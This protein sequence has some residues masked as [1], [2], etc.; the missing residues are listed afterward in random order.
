MASVPV[1]SLD[2]IS[3]LILYAINST[4]S[5]SLDD[6]HLQKIIFQ[7]LKLLK[8]NPEDFG[9][10]PHYYGPYSDAINENKESLK[11]MGYLESTSRGKGVC[12]TDDAKHSSL[13]LKI[14]PDIGFRISCISEDFSKLSND[15]LLLTIYSDDLQ[16][17]GGKFIENS[18]VRN[19]ILGNRKSIATNM[20]LDGKVSLERS[21]EL[22]GMNIRDFSNSILELR[23]LSN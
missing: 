5:K 1:A 21:S 4:E 19:R 17:T 22:A 16:R 8:K 12:M 20:Y 10:R 3:K 18:E 14:R 2:E 6:T 11:S 9:Y 13:E 23:G 7:I 15:E